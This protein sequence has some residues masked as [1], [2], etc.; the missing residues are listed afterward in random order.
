M[1]EAVRG[2]FWFHSAIWWLLEKIRLTP[3]QVVDEQ[4]VARTHQCSAYLDALLEMARLRAAPLL[5]AGAA[6]VRKSGSRKKFPLKNKLL[7][8]DGR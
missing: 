4:V 6:F 1:E 8:L 5:P 2:L 7:S 3:E